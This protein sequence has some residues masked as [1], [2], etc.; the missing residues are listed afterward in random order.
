MHEGQQMVPQPSQWGLEGEQD[1]R[2]IGNIH[3]SAPGRFAR[4]T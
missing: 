4:R 3:Q 2:G 1:E